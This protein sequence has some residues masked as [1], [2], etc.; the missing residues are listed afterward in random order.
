MQVVH[1]PE[2]KFTCSVCKA[3]NRGDPEEF[4]PITNTQPMLYQA[5]CGCYTKCAPT[6]LIA[7]QVARDLGY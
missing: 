6:T 4:V 5:K 2:I 3:V 7:R 1:P